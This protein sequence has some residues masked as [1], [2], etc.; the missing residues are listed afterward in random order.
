LDFADWSKAAVLIG[1]KVHLTLEGLDEIRL[2]KQGINNS[3]Q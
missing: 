2:I 3:R 1:K